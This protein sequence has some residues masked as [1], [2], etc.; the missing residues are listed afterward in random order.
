VDSFIFYFKGL[1]NFFKLLLSFV[2]S[3]ALKYHSP[4]QYRTDWPVR[5]DIFGAIRQSTNTTQRVAQD[6]AVGAYDAV[7]N[8]KQEAIP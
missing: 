1:S 5:G 7:I 2:G 4:P 8:Y 3:S 6:H